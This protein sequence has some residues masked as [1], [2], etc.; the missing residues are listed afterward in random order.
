MVPGMIFA[1]RAEHRLGLRL[2]IHMGSSGPPSEGNLLMNPSEEFRKHAAECR[3]M[4][5]AAADQEERAAWSGM[6]ARW[7]ACA[8]L[9]GLSQDRVAPSFSASLLFRRRY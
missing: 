9:A 4:A 8:D 7:A 2:Q 3:R 5:R 6:A 1:L